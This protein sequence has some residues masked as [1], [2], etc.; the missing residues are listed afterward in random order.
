MESTSESKMPTGM[1]ETLSGWIEAMVGPD[2]KMRQYVRLAD[3]RRIVADFS[4]AWRKSESGGAMGGEAEKCVKIAISVR[5][6]LD[7]IRGAEVA[8]HIVN[9]LIDRVREPAR[10]SSVS[11]E[12]RQ[13][14]E[15]LLYRGL[16]IEQYTRD[17]LIE[18]V[19]SLSKTMKEM[20]E[21][22]M[23]L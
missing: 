2:G 6:Q 7:D 17:E 22:L 18:I 21:R 1:D 23:G 8:N 16:P 19:I 13:N 14:R 3:H 5:D 9:Q 4:N 10:K 20:G 12:P 11:N 15:T